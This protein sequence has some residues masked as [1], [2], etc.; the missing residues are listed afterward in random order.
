[1][2]SAYSSPASFGSASS[3][4]SS[5]T[6]GPLNLE[7]TDHLLHDAIKPQ[8]KE[9]VQVAIGTCCVHGCCRRLRQVDVALH[10]LIGADARSFAGCGTAPASCDSTLTDKE[11]LRCPAAL[12]ASIKQLLCRRRTAHLT[13]KLP[14]FRWTNLRTPP[15]QIDGNT[16]TP[17]QSNCNYNLR[18]P[19]SSL[20]H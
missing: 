18:T 14:R 9:V 13:P 5:G 12:A 17:S 8:L 15:V 1:M 11:I 3:S 20:W 16:I 10:C 4:T 7:V 2:I 19:G 6:P